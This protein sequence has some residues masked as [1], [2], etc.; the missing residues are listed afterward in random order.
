MRQCTTSQLAEE[1]RSERI[2]RQGTTL[3]VPQN[4]NKINGL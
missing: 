3:V 1:F 4:A 2:S